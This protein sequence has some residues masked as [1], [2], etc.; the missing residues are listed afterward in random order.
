VGVSPLLLDEL[1]P[2][3]QNMGNIVTHGGIPPSA[4]VLQRRV[5]RAIRRAGVPEATY[6]WLRH[7]FGTVALAKTG[8]LLAVSRA[9]GHSSPATTARYAATS[10]QALDVIAAAVAQAA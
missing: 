7:R 5:N 8:D 10:D 9:M 2:F 3:P 6:H 1:L 4:E